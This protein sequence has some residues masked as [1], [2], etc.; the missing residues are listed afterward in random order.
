MDVQRATGH[1]SRLN[2]ALNYKIANI[3]T[4]YS[5]EWI[6][7]GLIAY[8]QTWMLRILAR[9]FISIPILLI[10]S[11]CGPSSKENDPFRT[12]FFDACMQM[13]PYQSMSPE[14]RN[15]LCKCTY[16][17]TMAGLSEDAQ[18]TARFY[19]LSQ[20]G[21]KPVSKSLVSSLPDGNVMFEASKA[22]GEAARQ[23]R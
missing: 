7:C 9:L 6:Y 21:V 2:D 14:K 19:L 12:E 10:L 3:F 16:D 5:R 1:A 15:N 8:R 22:I 18:N 4:P 23:C 20:A 11:A 17:T 13:K